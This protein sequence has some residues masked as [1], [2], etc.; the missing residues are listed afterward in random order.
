MKKLLEWNALEENVYLAPSNK[1]LLVDP[2]TYI[3]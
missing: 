1:I 3:L 2:K